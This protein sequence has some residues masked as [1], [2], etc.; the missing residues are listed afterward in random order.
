MISKQWGVAPTGVKAE[1][2]AGSR[3]NISDKGI[4]YGRQRM[5][6]VVNQNHADY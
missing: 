2:F 3:H 1:G 4:S 5:V 6:N